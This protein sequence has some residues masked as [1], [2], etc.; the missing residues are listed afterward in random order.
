MAKRL[1]DKQKEE[2]T[3][4]FIDGKSIDYL[5]EKFDCTKLTIIRNLKKSLGE[6][7]YKKIITKF[8]SSVNQFPGEK[9]NNKKRNKDIE[10]K[11]SKKVQVNKEDKTQ[12][13]LTEEKFISDQFV[14]ISPLNQEIDYARQKD[15]SSRN[16]SEIDLPNIV[17]LIVKKEIEL[18]TKYLR[19]YPEWQFLPEDDLNRKTIEIYFDVKTAKNNC[20]KDQKVIKVPNTDVFRIVSPIL[21]TRG[22]SRIVT[23]D[24][25]I[26][27]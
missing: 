21:I 8:K 11:I 17:F 3:S 18:E 9:E 20:N 6:N 25:L 13:S 2:I 10:I 26:S 27:L 24:N 7:K 15:L 19:D 1:L 22:I 12:V 23:K 16:L 5:S 4:G 14:E